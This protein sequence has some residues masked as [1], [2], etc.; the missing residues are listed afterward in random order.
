MPISRTFKDGT[1]EE[2]GGNKA[3]RAVRRDHSE[4][5][6]NARM[7]PNRRGEQLDPKG[8]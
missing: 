3:W 5:K 8:S 6:T 1:S 4:E 2:S 7:T